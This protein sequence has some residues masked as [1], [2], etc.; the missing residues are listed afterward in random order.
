MRCH[1]LVV[2]E[3][4]IKMLKTAFVAI[5]SQNIIGAATITSCTQ[6]AHITNIYV[7]VSYKKVETGN[8]TEK[9]QNQQNVTIIFSGVKT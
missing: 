7:I 5:K 4:K 3:I 6:T 8:L 9:S 2:S 1:L